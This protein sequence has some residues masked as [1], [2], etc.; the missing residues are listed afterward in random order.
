MVPQRVDFWGIPLTWG[1]P[2]IYVYTLMFLAAAILLWRFYLK[3]RSWVQVGRSESRWNKPFKRL[4][5]L[6]KY[7]IVQ[8]K[9][10][11]QRYP[12]VMHVCIAW[13]FFIFLLGT[14]LATIDSHFYKILVG[15][16][17]LLH[18]LVMDLFIIVFFIGAGLAIYRRFI[19]KPAR[20]TLTA[21]FTWSLVLIN[22]IILGGLFTESLRLAVE[23][24]AWAWWSPVG[25]LV[26]NFWIATGAN[27]AT[28]L[29]WHLG[30]WIS[31]L[32]IVA[33]TIITLPVGTLMH[34][35]SGPM[36][37]F[38]ADPEKNP[39]RLT[40]PT[41]NAKGESIFAGSIEQLSWFQLLS[42][43]GCTEC[44]RCQEACPA[45]AAGSKLNPKKVILAVRDALV[46]AR[47]KKADTRRNLVGDWIEDTAIWSCTSCMACIQECPVLIN[48]LDFIVDMRRFL[49][50]EGRMD[51]ELQTALE[52]FGRYGNSFGQSERMRAKWTQNILPKIKDARREVVEYLWFVGDYASYSPTLME[53]TIKTAEVFNKLGLDFGI[54]Y[55]AERN[56]G[57]DI[58]RI[59]EEGLFEMLMEKNVASIE[60]AN[61]KTIITSDPHSYNTLKNEYPASNG[62]QVLHYAELIDQMLASG[63]ITFNKKLNL[64]VT[65]HDPCYLGRYNQIFAAPRRVIQATGCQLVEMPR[66]ANRA[67]CCG[68]GGGRIWMPEGEIKERPSEIRIKEGVSLPG[69]SDFIVACPKDVTMFR[70][71]VKTTGNESK[72]QVKDLI[73][74][75]SEAL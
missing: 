38:F 25:W 35:L 40:V 62:H 60:K 58:R 75:V 47:V 8:T 56:S 24:P 46:E 28:F 6:I 53:I 29:G 66:H 2:A 41:E 11:S 30:I 50:I 67:F 68:A 18:K 17:Y 61:F 15:T 32:L 49:V 42:S 73:E 54:L 48:H 22:L 19:Q 69:V 9:V 55:D 36:N 33:L 27:E 65:Y 5:N 10:L 59:G 57:N 26:A 34:V 3:A 72:L 44:G 74:L 64:T 4:G 20:L 52:N 12:G 71:A 1:S 13:S 51:N 7:A 45:V 37:I 63:K 43:E 31:H 21:G 23:K 16:P 70:D 39:G 14:A